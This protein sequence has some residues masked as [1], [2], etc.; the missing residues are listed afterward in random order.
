[1]AYL[2]DK[3]LVVHVKGSYISPYFFCDYLFNALLECNR[4][5]VSVFFPTVF[6]VAAQCLFIIGAQLK[7]LSLFT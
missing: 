2:L 3:M 5:I 1:M 7:S 4:P 6:L